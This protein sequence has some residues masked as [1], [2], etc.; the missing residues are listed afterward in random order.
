M[1]RITAARGSKCFTKEIVPRTSEKFPDQVND[2]NR[3]YVPH[4]RRPLGGCQ[5]R[6]LD[7]SQHQADGKDGRSYLALVVG[8]ILNGS[9]LVPYTS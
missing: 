5:R 4:F 9:S 3:A 6:T 8:L 7:R 2:M 1:S